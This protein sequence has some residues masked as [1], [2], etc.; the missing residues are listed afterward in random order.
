MKKW[1]ADFENLYG[2]PN[3]DDYDHYF[4]ENVLK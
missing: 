4:Y 2:K 1:K 3:N